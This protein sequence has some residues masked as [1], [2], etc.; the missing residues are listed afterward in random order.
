V[1]S[2]FSEFMDC[3]AIH[4]GGPNDQGIEV[5]LVQG[6]RHYVVQVKRRQ[7]AD[8]VESVKSI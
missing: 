1:A 8:A 3:E 4:V 5:I 6:E 7:L 2:V